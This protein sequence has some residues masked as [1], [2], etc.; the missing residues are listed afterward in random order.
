[1]DAASVDP[2]IPRTIVV[3]PRQI[4][5]LQ[6][7]Q[8]LLLQTLTQLKSLANGEINQFMDLTL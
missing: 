5:D 3:G 6:E 1:M 4:T 2:S 7:Q 8:K